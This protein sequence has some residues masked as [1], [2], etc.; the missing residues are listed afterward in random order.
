MR[1]KVKQEVEEKVLYETPQN[2]DPF[3]EI[4]SDE[5]W[6]DPDGWESA[7]AVI[8]KPEVGSLLMGTYDG[9]EPFTEGKAEI[10]EKA[11]KHYVIEWNTKTRYSFVGGQ[12]FDKTIQNAKIVKGTDVKIKYLGQK[13]TSQGKRVNL[14]DIKCRKH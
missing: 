2:A 14:F 8:W 4:E 5:Y 9:N 11:L 10:K 3:E 6:D 13:D 7:S 12:V 1:K